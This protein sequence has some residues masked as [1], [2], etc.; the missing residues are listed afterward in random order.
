MSVD[1][2]NAA[3]YIM[4]SN[5]FARIT[6]NLSQYDSKDLLTSLAGLQLVP[7]NA[8]RALRFEVL[9]HIITLIRRKG[10]GKTKHTRI[11]KNKL[12]NLCKC[13]SS[14]DLYY[15]TRLEDPCENPF[16]EFF[17]YHGGSYVVFP[18]IFENATFIL[19]NLAKAIF[20]SRSI[21]NSQFSDKAHEVFRLILIPG[22]FHSQ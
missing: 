18:S 21:N 4:Q 2:F 19:Q 14:P 10:F 20:Y 15:V 11:S 5:S 16:T 7:E 6:R 13:E 3:L 8:D 17:T 9:I 22:L 12:T 1:F